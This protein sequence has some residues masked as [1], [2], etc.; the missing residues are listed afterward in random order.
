MK[1]LN[2]TV[3][4]RSLQLALPHAQVEVLS[5]TYEHYSG[6]VIAKARIDGELET[7]HYSFVY[8]A[9]DFASDYAPDYLD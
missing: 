7:C 4:T 3:I 6:Q 8:R 1:G 9:W 5:F 2:K